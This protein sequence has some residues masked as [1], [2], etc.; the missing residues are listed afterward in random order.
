MFPALSENDLGPMESNFDIL[1]IRPPKHNA[2]DI[3]KIYVLISNSYSITLMTFQGSIIL[4][5]NS[6]YE[7]VGSTPIKTKTIL[8][9]KLKK[10]STEAEP[11]LAQSFKG[12]PH[13]LHTSC[14]QDVQQPSLFQSGFNP[15]T[16]SP[17]NKRGISKSPQEKISFSLIEPQRLPCTPA[18]DYKFHAPCTTYTPH[19]QQIQSEAYLG[20]SLTSAGELFYGNSQP[21]K[22]VGYFCR[23]AISWMFYR[24]LNATLPI[25]LFVYTKHC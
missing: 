22:P 10:T 4:T 7:W 12:A 9:L 16:P 13:T 20:S 14:T 25:I 8:P 11:P 3:L 19:L 21:I 6:T 5:L 24:I 1:P 18:C 15:F 23:R 2:D 17:M